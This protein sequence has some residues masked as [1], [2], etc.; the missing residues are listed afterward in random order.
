MKGALTAPAG[1][2]TLAGTL[3]TLVLL[4]DSVISAPPAGAGLLRVAV[5]RE[6]PP[7]VTVVGFNETADRPTAAGTTVIVVCCEITPAVAVIVAVEF[8]ATGTLVMVKDALI[9]PAGTVT[10]AGTLTTLVSLLDNFTANPPVGAGA[11][12][13]TVPTAVLPLV[14]LVGL[15]ETEAR[16]IER[17]GVAVRTT[18]CVE[19]P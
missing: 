3:T 6:T 11:V 15:T 7:P 9:A 17:A 8:D 12:R 2:V 10:L 5:P 14:T 13:V 1:T 4:L 18:D 16:L 19:A